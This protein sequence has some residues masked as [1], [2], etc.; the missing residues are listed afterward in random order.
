MQYI[1]PVI[2]IELI[3]KNAQFS[4]TQILDIHSQIMM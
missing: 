1:V 3:K 2:S 4:I